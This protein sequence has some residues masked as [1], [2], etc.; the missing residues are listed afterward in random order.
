[1]NTLNFPAKQN[2]LWS[3]FCVSSETIFQQFRVFIKESWPK[4]LRCSGQKVFGWEPRGPRPREG[5]E[6]PMPYYIICDGLTITTALL[7]QPVEQN[8]WSELHLL[9]RSTKCIYCESWYV[10]SKV[11]LFPPPTIYFICHPSV[12]LEPLV[13]CIFTSPHYYYCSGEMS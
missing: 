3:I 5:E 6:R 9:I 2:I 4:F 1:M 8:M 11:F 13:D 12:V 7:W 10:I